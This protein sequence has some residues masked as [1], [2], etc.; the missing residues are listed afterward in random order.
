MPRLNICAVFFLL[1]L[2]FLPLTL[3]ATCDALDL[4]LVPGEYEKLKVDYSSFYRDREK[5]ISLGLGTIFAGVSANT[6]LDR[7]AQEI[8]RDNVRNHFTDEASDIARLPGEPAL[9]LTALVGARVIFDNTPAGDWASDSLRA[10]AVGAPTAL[11]LQY[12]TGGAR[13]E[14][15][16]SSWRPFKNN[17]GL[18]GHAFL[19][20]T[21]FLA[22]AMKEERAWAK[23][24]LYAA[25]ALPA[26]SRINDGKHYLSQA[27]LGWHLAYLSAS[28]VVKGKAEGLAITVIP[29]GN[30]FIV[31]ADMGF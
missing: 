15:G 20:A 10:I 12:S 30:G 2:L 21:P 31:K 17:N 29:S 5:L 1:L 13:P 22:A 9:V 28:A 8:W 26:L 18:S 14:E 7:E 24:L 25:S 27:F 6:S 4:K 19:G 11:F 23:T 3:P 16:G